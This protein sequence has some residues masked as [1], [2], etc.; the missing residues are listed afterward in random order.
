MQVIVM[1]RHLPTEDDMADIYTASA[2]APPLTQIAM[3]DI[4]RLRT[5]VA[6]FRG[7]YSHTRVIVSDNPRGR[8]S[9]EV[10]L[11]DAMQGIEFDRRLNNILQ[12]EWAGQ[13]QAEVSTTPLYKLWH[14]RPNEV[15]FSN[16]ERLEDVALRVAT[17]L[18]ELG[19]VSCLLLSH[20]TPMQ[21]LVCLLLGLSIDHIWAFKFDHLRFSA[22]S[23]GVLLRHNSKTVDDLMISDL[24]LP[25]RE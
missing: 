11:N 10:L 15:R 21:A 6:W 9:A 8:Q 3:Q 5:Q 2:A 16:G 19:D 12:P 24:R 20:T 14:T 25:P 13:T 18:Q 22:V 17:L 23:A 4:E 7:Q 1:L